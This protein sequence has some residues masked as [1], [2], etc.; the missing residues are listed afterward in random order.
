MI[1][2][3]SQGYCQDSIVGPDAMLLVRDMLSKDLDF[4]CRRASRQARSKRV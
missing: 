4:S 2:G 3:F 1:S